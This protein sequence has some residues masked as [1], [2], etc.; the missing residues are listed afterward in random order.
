MTVKE[1]LNQLVGDEDELCPQTMRDM[2]EI[3]HIKHELES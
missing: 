2:I 1:Y 3:T